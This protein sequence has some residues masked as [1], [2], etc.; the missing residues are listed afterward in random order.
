MTSPVRSALFAAALMAAFAPA[1]VPAAVCDEKWETKPANNLENCSELWRAIGTPVHESTAADTTYVCHSRYVLAHNNKRKT[2]DWVL[3]RLTRAQAT[4]D[5]DRPKTSFKREEAVCAAAAASDDDYTN[6][7]FDRGHMAPSDD[8]KVSR[9]WMI[10]SFILSNIV[11]QVGVGFNQGIWKQ[12][13]T[14]VRKVALD[15]GEVYVIT[16]PIYPDAAGKFPR[17]TKKM[18]A[19]GQAIE[20][21][22]PPKAAI[23]GDN[24][25]NPKTECPKGKSVAVPVA[26]YKIIYDPVRQR[27]NAYI[28]PNIDH[29]GRETTDNSIDY[30]QR[31]RTTLRLVER[32]TGL[33]FFP[34]LEPRLRRIQSNNCAATMV[35]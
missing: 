35:H 11:P 6:S 23:C 32:Y 12:L 20:F 8:F 15:R 24:D 31:H 7:S 3:E 17:I 13:E 5:N 2:P 27:T 4:G 16:G 29:R 33:R 19:C 10:E 28:M 21:P 14:L 1:S 25:K 22:R 30:L 18:N 9:D 34:D 26:L